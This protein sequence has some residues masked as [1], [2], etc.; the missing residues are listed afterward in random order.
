MPPQCLCFATVVHSQ[1]RLM[2]SAAPMVTHGR[3][4][5]LGPSCAAYLS[6]C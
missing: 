2:L 3:G 5:S 1:R 4:A 6:H